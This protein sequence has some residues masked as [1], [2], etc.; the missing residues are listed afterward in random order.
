MTL[1]LEFTNSTATLYPYQEDEWSRS[2]ASDG[3]ASS[4]GTSDRQSLR[5]APLH[6]VVVR[7]GAEP[8]PVD[9]ASQGLAWYGARVSIS[10]TAQPYGFT[11]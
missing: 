2:T 5:L 4:G 7:I 9:I 3:Y 10:D 11:Q 1:P 8:T 6:N